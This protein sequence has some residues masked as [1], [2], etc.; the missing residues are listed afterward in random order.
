MHCAQSRA[1][2]SV[3]D[4]WRLAR[5]TSELE[6]TSPMLRIRATTPHA[7]AAPALTKLCTS[8][9]ERAIFGLA[10][11]GLTA[12]VSTVA[13]APDIIV[14][15]LPDSAKSGRAGAGHARSGTR[16]AGAADGHHR[17]IT[18]KE[19]LMPAFRSRHGIDLLPFVP[20]LLSSGLLGHIWRS[21]DPAVALVLSEFHYHW[22]RGCPNGHAAHSRSIAS[23]VFC[24][25]L[26]KGS[27]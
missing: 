12:P 20:P 27:K 3:M 13:F 6:A 17:A 4:L 22:R 2:T 21:D 14:P 9:C 19:L 18:I 11:R 26:G 7:A 1:A 8:G 16:I 25:R 15:P 24:N 10:T 5:F 23:I